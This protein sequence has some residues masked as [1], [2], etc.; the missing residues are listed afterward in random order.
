MR[1]QMPIDRPFARSAALATLLALAAC[2]STAGP[3]EEDEVLFLIEHRRYTEAVRVSEE[4]AR[5]APDDPKA[6]A[7]YRLASVALLLEQCRRACFENRD[8]EALVF[9]QQARELAPGDRIVE[10][11]HLKLMNKLADR[12]RGQAIE[13]H[14]ADN[15]ELAKLKFDEALHYAPNDLRSKDGA[16]QVLLQ[17]NFRAGMGE[18]YYREGA[19]ALSAYFLHEAR[20]FFSYTIKYQPKNDRA[21]ER[22]G[23]VSTMLAEDRT[24]IAADLEARGLYA[25]A[26]NEYRIALI[27]EPTFAAA[28]EGEQRAAREAKAAAVLAEADRLTMKKRF[29]EARTLLAA[30][31]DATDAQKERFESALADVEQRELEDLYETAVGYQADARYVEARDTFAA[32]LARAQYFK[33]AI[34]RKENVEGFIQRAEETYVQALAATTDEERISLLRRTD[35]YWPDYK[36]VRERLKALGANL[37]P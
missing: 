8:D 19:Q 31:R 23:E 16:A 3:K 35:L 20:S 12:A 9:A 4:R 33:D 37:R 36:D 13:A 24:A 34:T 22:R 28:I 14:A 29:D 18:S 21:A 2:A 5:K 7:D 11:W 30:N 25:A 6:Q 27:V 15:L 1:R 17:M 26:E 10:G 32:L